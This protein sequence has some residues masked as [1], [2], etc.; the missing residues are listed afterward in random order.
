MTPP[1]NNQT[2]SQEGSRTDGSLDEQIAQ[3]TTA[4]SG[5]KRIHT[6][7]ERVREEALDELEE[8][9]AEFIR[10]AAD[11]GFPIDDEIPSKA[12]AALKG[13]DTK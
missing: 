3:I 11:N 2:P 7:I 6:L 5:V 1:K 8:K 13:K 9:T 10:G 12:R 4:P